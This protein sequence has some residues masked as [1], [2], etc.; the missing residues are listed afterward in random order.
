MENNGRQIYLYAA[1]VD[2]LA[3]PELFR[4]A[5][6]LLDEKRKEKTERLRFE[7]DK[8]LCAGAGLLIRTALLDMAG[9]DPRNIP[10]EYGEHE[11][12]YIAGSDNVFFNISHSGDMVICAVG[13]CE[14]GCDIEEIKPPKSNVAER[15]FSEEERNF[16]KAGGDDAF[17]RI[18]TLKE[19]FMKATGLGLSLSMRDFSINM[20]PAGITV[21]QNVDSRK[22][23]FKEI[24]D[25]P[26]YKCAVCVASEESLADISVKICRIDPEEMIRFLKEI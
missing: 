22:Y 23:L 11:K 14:V 12:P 20:G 8:R 2:K 10:F 7:K 16:V 25:F 24:T 13:G 9:M 6:D 19:S 18:W 17:F 4:S 21:E 15:F 1:D 26:R 3:D 5:F